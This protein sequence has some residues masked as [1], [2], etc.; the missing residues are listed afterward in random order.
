[1]MKTTRINFVSATG[2]GTAYFIFL[3]PFYTFEW[4]VPDFFLYHS[5][6]QKA[7]I[8][9]DGFSS[10]FV[11]IAALPLK[12]AGLLHIFCLAAMSVSL[13]TLLYFSSRILRENH[14]RLL[15]AGAV[16]SCGIWYYFYGKQFYDLPFSMLSLSVTLWLILHL[17]KYPLAAKA[18]WISLGFFLSWKP[19]N[20]FA[21]AGLAFL[22]LFH[23]QYGRIIFGISISGMRDFSLFFAKGRKR[24]ILQWAALAAIGYFAG[25]FSIFVHPLKTI[26][27]ILA[28]RAHY[29]FTQ[30][31]F[32][33]MMIWD[34]VNSASVNLAVFYVPAACVILF[35]LPLLLKNKLFLMLS[36]GFSLIYFFFITMKSPGY[37]W[38]S[39]MFAVFLL[40]FFIFTLRQAEGIPLK[41]KLCLRILAGAAV[42][43][44]CLNNFAIYL[45]KEIFWFRQTEQ[46]IR[47]AQENSRII[48]EHV[49]ES[50]RN[51]DGGFIIHS[52]LQRY[53][54]QDNKKIAPLEE[55]RHA[56]RPDSGSP[57]YRV[58]ICFPML[59]SPGMRE[60]RTPFWDS[61]HL[62]GRDYP[63]IQ[64]K[65]Y[66]LYR[67]A[68]F[69][70]TK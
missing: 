41:N 28:Y 18:V 7:I 13:G 61:S 62:S 45:P 56:L 19:Y 55:S 14:N 22:L 26:K 57:K 59:H 3:L 36:S 17:E 29:S 70:I 40:F 60:I 33:N 21:A 47:A 27:G 66:G 68:I 38:H 46:A 15:A 65:D 10:L 30:H 51:L 23:P 1:M 25:N 8:A 9:H 67:I 69:D 37:V 35:I 49:E 42:A 43:A 20:I 48:Y 54:I 44:Q 53:S 5:F 11:L 64:A 52:G 58:V 24:L 16:L 39:F 4:Y 2:I 32:G 50:V 6:G 31:L 34:H 12:Y 63:L